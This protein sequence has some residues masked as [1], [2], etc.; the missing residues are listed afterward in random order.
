MLTNQ[1]RHGEFKNYILKG[2]NLIKI[3]LNYVA[4]KV[5]FA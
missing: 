5:N 2:L 4:D 3:Y 1:H